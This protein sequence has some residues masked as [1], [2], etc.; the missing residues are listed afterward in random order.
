[1]STKGRKAGIIPSESAI[2]SVPE[3]PAELDKYAKKVWREVLPN[4]VERR[5]LTPADIPGLRNF[6]IAQGTVAKLS[7]AIQALG[8]TFDAQLYR[9]Q[10]KAMT[11]ARQIGDQYGLSPTSRSRPS[12]REDDDGEDELSG[13]GF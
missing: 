3:P 11:T 4:L 1:M 12:I 5:I 9:A 13:L 8:E 7:R 2:N 10:D 6:C